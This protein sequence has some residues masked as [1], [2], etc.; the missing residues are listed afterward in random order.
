MQANQE[1]KAPAGASQKAAA[2]AAHTV[3][4]GLLPAQKGLL[5]G[6]LTTSLSTVPEGT[7]K[8]EGG[9]GLAAGRREIPRDAQRRWR[10]RQV[11]RTYTGFAHLA[12][13]VEGAWICG[14][15]HLPYRGGP[16]SARVEEGIP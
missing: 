12:K 7:A 8:A 16:S 2:A 9:N 13:A 15:P 10:C 1:V 11:P 4:G 6:A 3:L 5:D 14:G